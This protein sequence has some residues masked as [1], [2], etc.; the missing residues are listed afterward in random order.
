MLILVGA[1][2]NPQVDADG[3]QF[4]EDE[5]EDKQHHVHYLIGFNVG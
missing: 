3:G 1:E 2:V 5:G 4:Q